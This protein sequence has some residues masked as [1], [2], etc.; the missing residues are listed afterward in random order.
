MKITDIKLRKLSVA[1]EHPAPGVGRLCRQSIC[2]EFA[3]GDR[4]DIE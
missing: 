4:S 3:A 1:M 2:Q